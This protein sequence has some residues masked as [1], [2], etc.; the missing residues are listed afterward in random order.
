MS[1]AEEMITQMEDDLNFEE[2]IL[3]SRARELRRQSLEAFKIMA[4]VKKS[5]LDK[6]AENIIT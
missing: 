3:N 1:A 4:D 6:K 5:K 2:A